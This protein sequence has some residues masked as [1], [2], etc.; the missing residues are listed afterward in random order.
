M[1]KTHLLMILSII[2]SFTINAGE[3][4]NDDDQKQTNDHTAILKN[5]ATSKSILP[6][7]VEEFK[8][9]LDPSLDINTHTID[10]SP[11]LHYFIK[12]SHMKMATM[13][14]KVKRNVAV[15]PNITDNSGST[16]L[17]IAGE[18]DLEPTNIICTSTMAYNAFLEAK[19]K[20]SSSSH[21]EMMAFINADA[22]EALEALEVSQEQATSVFTMRVL[23]DI[24]A[25]TFS[26]NVGISTT[27]RARIIMAGLSLLEDPEDY[28][29]EFVELINTLMSLGADITLKNND[30]ETP[31]DLPI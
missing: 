24:L 28:K 13:I 15:N 12:R 9:C 11:C 4:I 17:H 3:T 27:E 20:Q 5:D 23:L 18:I 30:G 29:T 22:P 10:G 7:I 6:P 31:A 8:Y 2:V 25:N 19:V 1:K 21:E 16:P 26:Q 14:L